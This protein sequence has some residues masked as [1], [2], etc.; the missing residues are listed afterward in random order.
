MWQ[1]CCTGYWFPSGKR[2]SFIFHAQI[3]QQQNK[4]ALKHRG[5]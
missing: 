4:K 1:I 3:K 5:V 2:R